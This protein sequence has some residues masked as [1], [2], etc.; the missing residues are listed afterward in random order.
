MELQLHLEVFFVIALNV[1][2]LLA[3]EFVEVHQLRFQ[4]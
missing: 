3:I 4:Y 1:C 2:G